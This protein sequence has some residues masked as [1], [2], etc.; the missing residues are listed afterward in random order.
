MT[1]RNIDI[2]NKVVDLLTEGKTISEA[3]SEVYTRRKV[4]IPYTEEQTNVSICALKFS[5]RVQHALTDLELF[6]INDVVEYANKHGVKS[7]K[8]MGA[9][10][11]VEVLEKI[12][13][14]LWVHMTHEERVEFLID[15]VENNSDY[16]RDGIA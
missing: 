12:L 7:I 10:S 1:Q 15:T 14:Y 11:C 13:N 6:T 3:L 4:Q 8:N 2:M 9:K 5:N 16:V